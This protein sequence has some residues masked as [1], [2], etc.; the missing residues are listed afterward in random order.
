MKSQL[1]ELGDLAMLVIL[2]AQSDGLGKKFKD[3][4]GQRW[5]D[6]LREKKEDPDV[7]G[8]LREAYPYDE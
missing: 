2:A 3:A 6:W 7:G 1:S 4:G 5:K 8:F